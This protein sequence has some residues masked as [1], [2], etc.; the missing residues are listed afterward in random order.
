MQQ[1]EL[2]DNQT[3][4]SATS[5]H[6]GYSLILFVHF[7]PFVPQKS[8]ISRIPLGKI[9]N[10]RVP[11]KIIIPNLA[12]LF[13]QNPES[14]PSNK[15]NPGSRK[16]YWGP[17]E[18][19]L[20]FLQGKVVYHQT[21]TP[22]WLEAHAS[23]IDSSRTS[24]AQQLTF[25]AGASNHAALLKVPMIPAGVFKASTPLTVEIT[26]ANDINIGGKPDSDISY[27]VSDGARF[28]GFLTVDKANYGSYAPCYGIEG[29]SGATLTSLKTNPITPTPSASFYPG[30]FVF[31][32]KLDERW[33]SCFTGHGG[34]FVRTAGYSNRLILSN[35]INLM[36]Y[37]E[38]KHEKVGIKFIKVTII[39]DEA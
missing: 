34:G 23:Y 18:L 36:V 21:M 22:T 15:P 19:S 1:F 5:D 24:T 2:S 8:V 10:S 17:S 28:V 32:L 3:L 33:G 20:S 27:G 38:N 26:V 39:Q 16:T 12:P 35:G 9:A 30:Q 37:K 13:H 7:R 6:E 4:C 14:R 31:T 11:F 29:L 25:N